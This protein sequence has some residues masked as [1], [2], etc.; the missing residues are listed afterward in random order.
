MGKLVSHIEGMEKTLVV[1]EQDRREDRNC[2]DLM[3]AHH[4]ELHRKLDSLIDLLS[5]QHIKGYDKKGY[6]GASPSRVEERELEM[7]DRGLWS[8]IPN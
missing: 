6:D 2:V 7:E 8:T 3:E 1:L 5:A 4:K